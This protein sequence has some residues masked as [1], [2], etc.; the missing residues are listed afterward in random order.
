MSSPS[1][2]LDSKNS[3][4]RSP[5]YPWLA[6]ESLFWFVGGNDPKA[7]AKAKSTGKLNELP[8]NHSPQFAPIL[9][10]T[11]E[12]GVE[13]LVVDAL[14]WLGVTWSFWLSVHAMR[15]IREDA[16]LFI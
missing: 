10:P 12:T 1:M 15:P 3:N 4:P 7:Y 14:A 11:L 2:I 8:V 16:V 13:A 5:P 9:H 6:I